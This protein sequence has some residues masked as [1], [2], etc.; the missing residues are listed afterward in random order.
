MRFRNSKYWHPD[1]HEPW[2]LRKGIRQELR[3]QESEQEWLAEMRAQESKVMADDG[4]AR[5]YEVTEW[6]V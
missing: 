3:I 1:E 6:K 5:G 2:H 4:F